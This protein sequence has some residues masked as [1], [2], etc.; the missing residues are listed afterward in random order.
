MGTPAFA[1]PSLS[2]FADG[3]HNVVGVVTQPDR[4][5]GRGLEVAESAVK[6]LAR[7]HGLPVF[8][9]EKINR[10]DSLR[11]VKEL[12]PHLIVVVAYGQILSQRV[13]DIPEEGC[14]NVHASLLPK[15]R[16]AA[17]INWAVIR[18]EKNT[19][20]TTMLM[21]SGLDTGDILQQRSLSIGSEETAGELHDRLAALGADTLADT[22]N[23]WKDRSILPQK[24]NQAEATYAPQLTKEQGR[25]DWQNPAEAIHNQVRGMNPWPGAYTLLDGKI[26]R[27]HR[28][29][30]LAQEAQEA[31]GTVI[32]TGKNGI[33]VA[34]GEGT[35]M[36]EEIQL[37]GKK[38]L[39]ADA[40][41]QGKALPVGFRLG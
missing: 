22:V 32:G 24:Q 28:A 16:G 4:R 19:G 17:P 11:M 29:R 34:T 38:R 21:D 15:Y 26:L 35:L 41:L 12:A 37:Q 23:R 39:S 1:C 8:Q 30:Q 40:F 14:I 25:I 3:E 6:T 5:R 7:K 33:A 13:L 27:I 10:D 2:T 20:V 9:P 31:P 36:I 18:G